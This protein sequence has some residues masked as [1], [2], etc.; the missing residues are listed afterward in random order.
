MHAREK[1]CSADGA[2]RSLEIMDGPSQWLHQ[3]TVIRAGRSD[4]PAEMRRQG[5]RS[6]MQGGF[7]MGGVAH[8]LRLTD[9]GTS[10]AYRNP[11]ANWTTHKTMKSTKTTSRN[12]RR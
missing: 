6:A 4:L 8:E 11:H 2:R 7:R 5:Y 9:R 10:L 3:L 12:N 1:E